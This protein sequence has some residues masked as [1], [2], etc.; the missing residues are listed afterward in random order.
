LGR[1]SQIPRLNKGG[2]GP[3][4]KPTKGT[5]PMTPYVN[6]IDNAKEIAALRLEAGSDND[7][8]YEAVFIG[9]VHVEDMLALEKAGIPQGF[10]AG[11]LKSQLKAIE[12]A[13]KLLYT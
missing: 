4:H 12:A 9:K 7:L 1:A 10:K 11:V 8:L 5:E 2:F 3:Y 6:T 13:L